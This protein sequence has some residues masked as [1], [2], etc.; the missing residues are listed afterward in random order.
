MRAG[1]AISGSRRD[2]SPAEDTIVG[3]LSATR[4]NPV[5][6]GLPV[7][8]QQMT[9]TADRDFN[10]LKASQRI[11]RLVLAP[12]VDIPY[13]V[14]AMREAIGPRKRHSLPPVLSKLT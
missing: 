14:L 4:S 8:R 13:A 2:L 11:R 6:S 9:D 5:L 10:L 7:I 3:E 1:L 12:R